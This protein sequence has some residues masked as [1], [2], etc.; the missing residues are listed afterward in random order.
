MVTPALSLTGDGIPG[1]EQVMVKVVFWLKVTDVAPLKPT[2]PDHC[3]LDGVDEAVQEVVLEEVQLNVVE[4]PDS[5][6]VG[7]A[8]IS[9]NG[10][11][12]PVGLTYSVLLQVRV[13]LPLTP[14]KVTV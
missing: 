1:P 10:A 13:R 3:P 14:V 2:E 7:K 12:L 4:P 5:T 9:T 6:V 11:G 8:A